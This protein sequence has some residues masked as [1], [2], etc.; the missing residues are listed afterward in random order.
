MVKP[1]ED[2]HGWVFLLHLSAYLLSLNL[3]R[4]KSVINFNSLTAQSIQQCRGVGTAY[5]TDG[6]PK[7]QMIQTNEDECVATK[8]D[9]LLRLHLWLKSCVTKGWD[10]TGGLFLGV[11][12]LSEPKGTRS[13][14]AE[15][16]QPVT[17]FSWQEGCG[18]GLGPAPTVEGRMEVPK[19]PYTLFLF[20]DWT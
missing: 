18:Q 14:W 4:S 6:E 11:S 8:L 15:S 7:A 19:P 1:E 9:S 3:I 10:G 5:L 17:S 20:Q 2:G 13:L 16:F 12:V